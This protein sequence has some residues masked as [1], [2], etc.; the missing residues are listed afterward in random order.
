M[1]AGTVPKV[2]FGRFAGPAKIIVKKI[3]GG[4]CGAYYFIIDYWMIRISPGPVKEQLGFF[5]VSGL[6]SVDESCKGG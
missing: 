1:V 5:M 2:L 3:I 4:T 6:F